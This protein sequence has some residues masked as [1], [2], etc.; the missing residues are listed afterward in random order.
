MRLCAKISVFFEKKPQYLIFL[1]I[2]PVIISLYYI[3]TFG[4]SVVDWDQWELVPYLNKYFQGTLTIAD[5]FSQ[6]NE[7]RIFFPRIAMI[8]IA[9]LTHYNNIAEMVFSWIILI[10]AFAILFLL[11]RTK[12]SSSNKYLLLFVPI[13]WLF[14]SLKQY[15]NLLW[16]W[17]IQIC[18]C[19][20][21]LLLAV[22][23]LEKVEK[24]DLFF[25]FAIIGGI[26]S[27]YSFFNGLI[28]WI[29]GA[30]YLLIINKP[31]ILL[32]SWIGASIF[33][34][35]IFFTT[36]TPPVGHPSKLFIFTDPIGAIIY[37]IANIGS[38]L[39][40][41]ESYVSI[42]TGIQSAIFGV[43]ILGFI[44]YLLYFNYQYKSFERN[45]AWWTL[46][47]FSLITSI[48]LSLWRGVL[49]IGQSLSSRYVTFTVLGII[50]VYCILVNLS[51]NDNTNKQVKWAFTFF[52]LLIVIGIILGNIQGLNKGYQINIHKNDQ[53][54][55]LLNYSHEPDTQLQK[56]YPDANTIRKLAPI[57][58][59]ARY[60]VFY[61][62][63][64][65]SLGS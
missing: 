24:L 22:Y 31:R 35:L 4:V 61:N 15:E 60:N 57:L 64:K 3:L 43:I 18:L 42:I 53:A 14:F 8:T 65:N 63:Q 39:S 54:N 62:I 38:G 41:G 11:F 50:G 7:H 44:L 36:W 34:F 45:A 55:I 28:V 10:I 17:Q 27:T 59:K 40:G 33:V 25:I 49:G 48:I 32:Y 2:S 23:C 26:I 30:F 19:S 1:I 12:F 46:I 56:L 52:T 58:E 29:V 21:G 6:H 9:Y 13:A 37:F 20:M 47:A 51:S 5:L 16:G